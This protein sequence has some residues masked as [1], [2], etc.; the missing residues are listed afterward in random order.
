MLDKGIKIRKCQQGQGLTEYAMI[1]GLVSV[2]AILTLTAFGSIIVDTFY[3]L[4]NDNF[5]GMT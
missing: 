3:S 2:A 4:I 1:L 5:P